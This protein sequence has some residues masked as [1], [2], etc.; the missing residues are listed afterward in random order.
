MKIFINCMINLKDMESDLELGQFRLL[1]VD[2]RLVIPM[3]C[4]IRL[5]VTGEKHLALIKFKPSLQ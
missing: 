5:I 2:N 4:H 1:D 3:D